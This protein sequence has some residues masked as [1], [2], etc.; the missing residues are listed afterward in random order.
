MKI[1]EQDDQHMVIVP[2]YSWWE[3]LIP[4]SLLGIGP[5]VAVQFFF[6][7]TWNIIL[8]LV[9]GVFTVRWLVFA[10]FRIVIDKTTQTVTVR[11]PVYWLIPGERHIQFSAVMSVYLGSKLTRDR[12]EQWWVALDIND[13]GRIK[14]GQMRKEEDAQ[15]LAEQIG[16]FIGL[17]LSERIEE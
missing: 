2:P 3:L 9:F 14:F 4:V 7:L 11:Q 13:G 17:E 16:G 10:Y 1:K 15:Y 12:R 5:I 8:A 6:S